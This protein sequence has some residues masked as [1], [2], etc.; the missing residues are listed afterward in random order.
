LI[1]QQSA[2]EILMAGGEHDPDVIR[3][4][5]KRAHRNSHLS[6]HQQ[7]RGVRPRNQIRRR[8]CDRPLSSVRQTDDDQTRTTTGPA[9]TDRQAAAKQRVT[10][11]NHPDLSDSPLNVHGIM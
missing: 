4:R 11:I 5:Q 6:L 7:R 2:L 9:I 8:T 3:Q 10:G 1:E